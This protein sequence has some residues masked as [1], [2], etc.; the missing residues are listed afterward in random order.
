MYL[1]RPLNVQN[2]SYDKFCFFNYPI[3][4]CQFK[5]ININFK[6]LMNSNFSKFFFENLHEA[7]KKPTRSNYLPPRLT[8]QWY[9]KMDSPSKQSYAHFYIFVCFTEYKYE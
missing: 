6:I 3:I 5:N 9:L 1:G 7:W 8:A 2:N 4:K